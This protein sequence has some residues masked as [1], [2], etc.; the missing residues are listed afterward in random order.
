MLEPLKINSKDIKGEIW[1]SGQF[2]LE[3]ENVRVNENGRL[4]L[5]KHPIAFEDRSTHPYITTDFS[6]SQIEMITPPCNSIHSALQHLDAIQHVVLNELKDEYLWPQSLPPELPEENQIPIAEFAN[7]AA[8]NDYRELLAIKYGKT[9]QMISGLHFNFS[10]NERLIGELYNAQKS[11]LSLEEFRNAVYLKTVRQLLRNRWIYVLLYGFSPISVSDQQFH[12]EPNSSSVDTFNNRLSI[13]NSCYGYKNH[14]EIF[15]DYTSLMSYCLSLETLIKNGRLA[16]QKEL[17]AP[18]RIKFD[19]NG[20]RISHIEIRFLDINPLVSTGVSKEQLHLLHL[21]IL[22]GLIVHEET[23]SSKHN[24]QEIADRNHN[25]VALNGLNPDIKILTAQNTKMNAWQSAMQQLDTIENL[26]KKL[27]VIAPEYLE[28]L[29]SIKKQL[30]NPYTRDVHAL[31]SSI[32]DEGMTE[33]HMRKAKEY[34][35]IQQLN[36]FCLKGFEDMELSTQLILSESIKRG[37]SFNILDRSENFIRLQK[38][39]IIHNIQQAT[40]TSLDNYATILSMENKLVTKQLLN[41]NNISVPFGYSY[42]SEQEAYVSY[43]SF[44]KKPVVIKPK[45]TNFGKGI[46]ILKDEYS[47]L[48]F[49]VAIQNAFSYDASIIIEEYISGKEFRFLIINDDI[50]GILFR[51]PAHVIGDGKHSTD[52]LIELKNQNPLRGTGY[53]SPLEKIKTDDETIHILK[54]QGRSLEYIPEL[55]ETVYLRYNSNISTGGDSFD[56]TDKIHDS[57]KQ[58]A[59]KAA[60]SIGTKITGLDMIIKD[61]TLQATEC[62]YSIIELNYNPAIH[63]HCYPYAGKNR[64]AQTKVLDALGF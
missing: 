15:P 61:Y 2:G 31:L 5:T 27:Q 12:C 34:S 23:E 47:E 63:I 42:D 43:Y 37:I 54:N 4:A 35:R 20:T 32:K 21:I 49:Q 60:Q 6:E 1:L 52:K 28:S 53:R 58:I 62:N 19:E 56:Y 30:V 48:E 40:K 36:S 55:N 50:T 44:N 46:T 16:S 26:L 39:N 45:Q 57:Y 8:Q 10:F 29:S 38:G 13:R 7:D 18:V 33:F 3:K 22:A 11:E 51:K 9:K 59:L 14:E 17:Y 64:M 41:E 25:T 24:W